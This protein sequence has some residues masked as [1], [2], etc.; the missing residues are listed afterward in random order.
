MNKIAEAMEKIVQAYK[1]EFGQD[2]TMDNGEEVV[3]VF[4][5]AVITLS[6]ENDIDMKI[7]VSVGT[8]YRF[9]ENIFEEE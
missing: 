6:K 4:N 9:D 7:N 2:A 8:P 5:D 1:E 3:G